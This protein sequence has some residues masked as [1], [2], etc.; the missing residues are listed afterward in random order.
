MSSLTSP[1]A[2]AVLP[3]TRHTG[4]PIERHSTSRKIT[5]LPSMPVT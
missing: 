2:S 1:Q 4:V 3:I 5:I